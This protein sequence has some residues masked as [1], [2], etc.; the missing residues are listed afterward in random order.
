MNLRHLQILELFIER[1]QPRPHYN[2]THLHP[3]KLELLTF[4][5]IAWMPEKRRHG[6]LQGQFSGTELRH[7][8]AAEWSDQLHSGKCDSKFVEL[9][10]FIDFKL[11]DYDY[12]PT[13]DTDTNCLI[14]EVINEAYQCTK[15]LGDNAIYMERIYLELQDSFKFRSITK[16]YSMIECPICGKPNKTLCEA[17]L[18]GHV[19]SY[20]CGNINCNLDIS[21]EQM[22]S[23]RKIR[24]L[25]PMAGSEYDVMTFTDATLNKNLEDLPYDFYKYLFHEIYHIQD[26]TALLEYDKSCHELTKK[27][28]QQRGANK[29]IKRH[30]DIN[31]VNL[32]TLPSLTLHSTHI[33]NKYGHSTNEA[34]IYRLNLE[35]E[36]IYEWIR[37]KK[38]LARLEK[39]TSKPTISLVERTRNY[40]YDFTPDTPSQSITS[41][42]PLRFISAEKSHRNSIYLLS[43]KSNSHA[44]ADF[45]HC[46]NEENTTLSLVN[47]KLGSNST[48]DEG[49][50]TALQSIEFKSGDI[51]A[52]VRGGGDTNNKTFACFHSKDSLG[53]IKELKCAG[54]TIVTGVGHAK[55]SFPIEDIANIKGITPTEAAYKLNEHIQVEYRKQ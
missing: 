1:Y 16:H 11:G 5:N 49:I 10:R 18:Q 39:I 14:N 15:N 42:P 27:K 24:H 48:K 51:L 45:E 35:I 43:T 41:Q 33:F 23:A 2:E 17:H 55:D 50:R 37:V 25:N 8:G 47:L 38:P 7:R 20:L 32:D 52:I 34:T 46:I 26:D 12:S 22:V 6:L 44:V 31:K 40:G 28:I 9:A 13:L 53:Y 54:V 4:N 36:C 21:P 29:D 3:K 30:I 19:T